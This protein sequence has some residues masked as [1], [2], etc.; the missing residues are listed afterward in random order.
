MS[1]SAV[2]VWSERAPGRHSFQGAGVLLAGIIYDTNLVT[3]FERTETV[4]GLSG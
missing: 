4:P 1:T 3:W 2:R